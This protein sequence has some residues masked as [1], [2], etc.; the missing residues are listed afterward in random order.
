[1]NSILTSSLILAGCT[2]TCFRAFSQNAGVE[3]SFSNVTASEVTALPQSPMPEKWTFD[4]CVEWATAN[5]TDVRR[6]ILNILQ[7]DENIG[8]AKDA[9]LPSVGFSTNHSFTNYPS[10][11]ENRT[12]NIYGSSYG[13]NASW[14]IWEGNVRK[15][16]LE[17]AK[18]ARRQQEFAGDDVVKNIKLGILQA[19]LNILYADEAVAI[20]RQTLEVS[21]SQTERA[22]KLMEAGR[23]S[24]VDY[25][26]IESQMAQDKYNLVQAEGNYAS[27]KM[28]LKK[29]L[30]LSLDYDLEIAGV[31][32]HDEDVAAPLPDM[33]TV[34]DFAASWLPEIKSNQL[35]KEIYEN[36]IKI[37]KAGHLP[38]I[39]LSGG[40]GTGYSSGGKSWGRQM[41]HGFNENVGINLSVPIYDANSTRRK[42]AK[43]KLSA[44]EY[45]LSLDDLL[46]NLSQTIEGLYIDARNAR[47]KYDAGKTQ[48]DA[49][50]LTADLV[51]RQFELGLVNPL[52]LL[53][54]HNNQIGRAHV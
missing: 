8:E 22:L 35:S 38:E 31:A 36:D 14:T 11:E 45:D 46:D 1:M 12:G 2:L 30:E 5:S 4:N 52:E 21:S 25:A 26:Q 15:Y 32:F 28:N 20:A 7:A 16:R 24:K 37:A 42:V 44:L 19:Y 50:R 47:A 34:Y 41:A 40:V 48:L 18:I 39:A 10:P 9:W 51:N 3:V 27:A 49:T 43:A 33:T 13:I 17:S 6:S 53:T 29:I 23:T 54:A